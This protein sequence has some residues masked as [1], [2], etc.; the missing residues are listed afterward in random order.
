MHEPHV[1]AG[2]FIFNLAKNDTQTTGNFIHVNCKAILPEN[3]FKHLFGYEK[4]AFTGAFVVTP[5][6]LEQ[7]LNGV[8]VLNGVES[9]SNE[10]QIAIVTAFEKEYFTRIGGTN[11]LSLN[12]KLIA[13]TNLES[14]ED[15]LK[16]QLRQDFFKLFKGIEQNIPALAQRKRDILPN[17]IL[18]LQRIKIKYGLKAETIGD[19]AAK[20]LLSYNWPGNWYEL[21]LTLRRAAF[22]CDDGYINAP[23]LPMELTHQSK[24]NITH[25]A[26]VAV[27]KNSDIDIFSSAQTTKIN[28]QVPK[29]KAIAAEAELEIIN[30]VLHSV[31]FNKTKAAKILGVD[32][33][34]L[35]NK[36]MKHKLIK[37]SDKN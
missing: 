9:L 15:G 11:Q 1:G 28:E 12:F 29:L 16:M 25:N 30:R 4:G 2:N 19:E 18:F 37:L 3:M 27:P 10:A 20:Y 17:A 32:R 8:L 26:H 31:K 21:Y 13:I 14:G 5:G 24:F 35:Y 6:V 22:L 23:E 33:K 34:T 36:M 7:S